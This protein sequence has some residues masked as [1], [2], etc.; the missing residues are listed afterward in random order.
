MEK[1]I[2]DYRRED[3]NNVHVLERNRL[4]TRPFYCGFKDEETAH[5]YDRSKSRNWFLLNGNWDFE[6]YETPMEVP[7]NFMNPEFFEEG[8]GKMA[9]PGHWQLNGYGKPHY[10]DAISL[11]PIL[12]E[13]SIQVDN[14]TG[15]Y[16]HNFFL[17]KEEDREYLL[18]FD[19]VESAYHVWLNGRFIGYS[20]GPRLTAEFDITEAL[21]DGENLLAVKVYKFCD[22]SYLENQDMW[23]FGGII[24]DVGIV[25]R[26]KIHCSDYKLDA[27]LVNQNKDGAFSGLVTVSNHQGRDVEGVI[28]LSI[29]KGG[30][31]LFREEKKVTLKEGETKTSFEGIIPGILAWSA[32]TPELYEVMM[33]LKTEDG[34]TEFYPERIGFRNVEQKDGL[35]LIN[36]EPIKFKGV[37]RHDW[38]QDKGRCITIEDMKADLRLMKANNINA[39]RTAHYP[40]HPDFLTLCDE[41]GFYVM[42][43]AD[44]E[45][46]Q[47]A[48]IKGKM[49]K[50]SE[51]VLWEASY[52]DRA[53]RMVDRDKNH[54]SILIWS[55]G[56]ESGFGSNFVASARAVR[57]RDAHRLIHYEEDRDAS[58]ADMYSSMY[59]RHAQL[60]LLGRDT[61]KK[62]P[63]V[64]C[65][66]AHA[67]GNGP[68][69]LKEYWEIFERYKRLQ[70]GFV[71]EWID[72]G[73]RKQDEAGKWYITYGGDYGDEPNSGAFCCDGLIQADRTPTPGLRELKKVL[74]P[75][76]A[77]DFCLES[78]SIS[79][80]NRYD[81]LTLDHLVCFCRVWS[82]EETLME[83]EISLEGIGPHSEKRVSIEGLKQAAFNNTVEDIW[84]DLSFC[85]REKPLW[86]LEDQEEVA[87]HQEML[88]ERCPEKEL[89]VWDGILKLKQEGIH[90][91]VSGDQFEAVFDR[92]RGNLCGYCIKG[93]S[94][95]E[96][97]LGLNLWRAPVDND[98]NMKTLWEEHMVNHMCSVVDRVEV[99]GDENRVVITCHQTYAPI[100]MEWK[101][102]VKSVY[103]VTPDG[104]IKIEVS[105]TPVGT[106][107]E[108][109][110]RI[111]LRF[112]LSGECEKVKWYGRGEGETY[113][114][115]K[116]GG[117]M[118]IFEKSVDDFYFPYVVPQE[119]GNREDT[120]WLMAK[121]SHGEVLW[122]KS[123]VPFCFS[124]L[125]Y[126]QE[127]LTRA[128]HTNELLRVEEVYL[129]VD[130]G[131]NGL[132][133]ASWG[134]EALEKD[135]LKPEPFHFVWKLS[136][137]ES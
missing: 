119:T 66:Y 91:I 30:A 56:N 86:A 70:G 69:G 73:I 16:R 62:K 12:D 131:Q 123:E 61:S 22:G 107:P 35:I 85:Y 52:V 40:S 89:K 101:I 133:S 44:L 51:D 113:P 6:Y 118:G 88:K 114:D 76:K 20:Q 42:E 110:P 55:L 64:V 90:V 39:V 24:R 98:K 112:L 136:G 57:E 59:T 83:T 31:Y 78:E 45:C 120:K 9:V 129:S 124:A 94:L 127:E 4:G 103:T 79:I 117:K 84:L 93:K 58:V 75:V 128:S 121:F 132:G 67:M 106:L 116:D 105:G 2:F 38:N 97:G 1:V 54:P 74:E 109:F 111:G 126:S 49:D 135:R 92:V 3:W 72:H 34:A 99:E 7:E 27:L 104:T 53:V 71:W 134:A 130:Y 137:G 115:C 10:N 81:F 96:K 87:F 43:E 80:K 122:L 26:E 18:R 47:M 95:I 28:A 37:N 41:M 125:H 50:L 21:L 8:W 108:C 102:L 25:S 48:Y 36:G 46:N 14:P 82:G 100:V 63:H 60:E 19:G 65:E 13:P 11:F 5:T 33:S 29:N 23:W 15:A 77:G 17:E 68:G 32:E